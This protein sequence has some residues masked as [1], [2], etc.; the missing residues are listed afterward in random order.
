M[1]Q[2]E[3]TPTLTVTVQAKK[4]YTS[5]TFWFNTLTII[6]QIIAYLT[7]AVTNP[8]ILAELMVGQSVINLI[9]RKVTVQPIN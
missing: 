9:L 6:A 8:N 3:I 1:T 5:K 2:T 4:W 7:G